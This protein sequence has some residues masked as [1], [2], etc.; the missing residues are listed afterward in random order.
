MFCE[1]DINCFTLNRGDTFRFTIL[2]NQGSK[3]NPSEYKLQET[4]TIYGAILQPNEAFEDAIIRKVIT[5]KNMPEDQSQP[6]FELLP[7]DTEYLR[8]GKYYFTLKLKQKDTIVTTILPM[9]EFWITGTTKD[10]GDCCCC[11]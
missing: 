4:D 8:T 6:V 7:Q 2:I 3:L 11:A 10:V 9:K 1:N 5:L